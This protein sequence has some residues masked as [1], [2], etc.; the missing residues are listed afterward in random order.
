M[1]TTVPSTLRVGVIGLGW[2][3]ETHLQSYL[4]LPNVEV[5]AIAD[6]NDARRQQVA[7]KYNI[8]AD[9]AD[10]NDLINRDDIDVISIATPNYLHAPAAIGAL[11]TGKHVLCEKPLA[12][13]ATDAQAMVKAA[14]DNNR[15][16]NVAFNHRQRPDVQL[17]KAYMNEG[18]LGNI[19]HAKAF[20]MRRSGIPGLG[21]W[22]TNRDT[23]G[24]GPLIDLGVHV[25]DMALFLMDE[26]EVISVSAA[27]YSELGK[28]GLG[29]RGDTV[30][31]DNFNVEDLATAFI[32]FAN[33][34]TLLL[35]ASW[36]VYGRQS[37][38]FGV[39]LYGTNGGADIDT[40]IHN[41]T[42][43]IF[44]DTAGVPAELR[45]RV[46]Q[47]SVGGHQV[48]VN[49]FID[50][51]RG[52]NWSSHTGKDGLLRSQIIEACYQSALEGREVS[53]S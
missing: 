44:T 7:T 18:N 4:N 49:K 30:S 19:Y 27:T 48:V 38:D 34:S 23:A 26:P 20:W 5:L 15:V 12:S 53:L 21:G 33:G 31:L 8:A 6:P 46:P 22:F 52:G 45:P 35:E 51:I 14:V 40:S 29:G 39:K 50:A 43:T 41:N 28:R 16:L 25:L 10:F 13:N 1:P 32:R 17:L 2:A 37:D 36:A 47:A 3:G 42:L 24:G 9:Y 11:S